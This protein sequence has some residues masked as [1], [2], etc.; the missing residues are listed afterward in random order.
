MAIL[1]LISVALLATKNSETRAEVA[2][3]PGLLDNL[4]EPRGGERKIPFL[5]CFVFEPKHGLLALRFG[6]N[7]IVTCD[8]CLCTCCNF[9]DFKVSKT[10]VIG[11]LA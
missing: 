7:S 4:V 11:A 5:F 3:H 9:Y 1:S 2:I 8:S 10:T 6:C